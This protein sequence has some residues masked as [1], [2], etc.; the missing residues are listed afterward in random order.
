MVTL[1]W[2]ACA[3][4]T[5][6]T[7]KRSKHRAMLSVFANLVIGWPLITPFAM[8]DGTEG[9]QRLKTHWRKVLLIAVLAGLEKN[10]TNSSL[11]SI[12]GALKTALHGLN[13]VFTFFVA[14]IAGADD[15]AYYCIRGCRCSGNLLLTISLILVACGSVFALPKGNSKE[16]AWGTSHWGVIFQ[17]G[18]GIAY[19]MKFTAIK[20]LLCSNNESANSAHRPP[21][22]AQVVFLCNP[23]IGLMS[24]ALVP[25]GGDWT[26]PEFSLALA[27]AAAAT[28]ILVLQMQLI[29]LLKSPVTVAV[30]AVFHDLAIVCYFV[31]M[32]G[33]SF[34]RAQVIG[35]TVSAVGAILYSCAKYRYSDLAAQD[36]S[37][38]SSSI[39]ND[40]SFSITPQT[41]RLH[42]SFSTQSSF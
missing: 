4:F 24:L 23:V 32:G 34:S 33:E 29:Q 42:F 41:M 16:E 27:V 38:C 2:Y 7:L 13:V 40:R 30:L 15:R 22:K 6:A 39:E 25:L 20:L 14:A 12:G 10:L 19:A 5:A 17:L 3:V 8:A 36:L 9:C 21:S 1:A 31:S 26:V 28:P 11:S 18:S 37:D 35:Y